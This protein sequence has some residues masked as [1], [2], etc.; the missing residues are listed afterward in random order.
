MGGATIIVQLDVY[1]GNNTPGE[2]ELPHYERFLG[3]GRILSYSVN[4]LNST[5][6]SNSI[7]GHS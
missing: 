3:S 5:E 1:L 6:L 7:L 2:Q 4:G